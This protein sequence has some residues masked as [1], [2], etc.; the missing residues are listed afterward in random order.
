MSDRHRNP[1]AWLAAILVPVLFVSVVALQRGIDSS[2]GTLEKQGDELLVKSGPL[3]KR[4]SLGYDALLADIYW[5]RAVQ[6]YG[7]KLPTSDRDF[8]LL[9]PLL[10]VAT[11]L[12]PYLVPAY[13]F[14]AFFLS[15][16]QGGA[17]RPDLA[18]DLVK[19]GI[20]AN[21]SNIQISAD[22]GFIYYMKLKDYERAAATYLETSKIPGAP[23]VFKILAARI[24]S[25]GG[26]LDTSRMIWSEIYETTK[27]EKIKKHALEELK[28]LKAQSD[29]IQLDQLAQDYHTRFGR[30]PQSTRE[31]V[32]AAMLKGVPVDPDGFPY[33]FGPDGKSQ[34]DPKSTIKIDPGAPTPK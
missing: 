18:V 6:Y 32:D 14:G 5:T 9:A 24:A 25:K 31:L 19:K 33:A 20:A 29:E 16:K 15:E 22:L 26:A 8:H 13:H 11:T 2:R 3:L 1:V 10:D 4:L 34:L 12:D 21:P 27:D 23:Q 30:Y 28:G 17:G 7:A